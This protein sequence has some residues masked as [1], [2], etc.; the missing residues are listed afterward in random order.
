[1]RAWLVS[2]QQ[3]LLSGL[4]LSQEKKRRPK[5]LQGLR[6]RTGEN[7]QPSWKRLRS[8]SCKRE[9]AIPPTSLDWPPVWIKRQSF[10]L[11][12]WIVSDLQE[13]GSRWTQWKVPR[14]MRPH[15]YRR[16]ICLPSHLIRILE[17][18]ALFT[19]PLLPQ[20]LGLQEACKSM[21]STSH[22]T[23]QLKVD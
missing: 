21:T 1:M 9:S 22:T 2:V 15:V 7:Y 23:S 6:C 16:T 10:L 19:Q 4:C 12:W 13:L 8:G 14:A 18:R 17:W 20:R 3:L 11:V 5:I